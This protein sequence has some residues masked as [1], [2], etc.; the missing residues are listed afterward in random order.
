[1]KTIPL[2]LVAAAIS[3]LP[4][5]GSAQVASGAGLTEL[6]QALP[7]KPERPFLHFDAQDLAA[8]RQ[9]ARTDPRTK[10]VYQALLKQADRLLDGED[11][12]AF[13]PE[14]REV[15]LSWIPYF[16]LSVQA[17]RDKTYLVTL[18]APVENSTEARALLGS[19][20]A[21]VAE[22]TLTCSVVYQGKRYVSTFD[23]SGN[24]RL[25]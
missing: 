15:Q 10:V 25:K 4:A 13:M 6:Q 20:N 9:R 7:R 17:S 16:D 18:F 24:A 5:L 19:S 2:I 12:H 11:R 14:I 21:V 23:L 8:M 22:N 3:F 1:M